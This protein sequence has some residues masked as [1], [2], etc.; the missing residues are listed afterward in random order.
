MIEQTPIKVMIVDDH[1]IVRDGIVNLAL[2]HDDI[3]LVGK[4]R[5]GLDLLD[6]LQEVMPDVGDVP[7]GRV[8]VTFS[9]GLPAPDRWL[10]R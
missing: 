6:Q 2:I 3:E 9:E 1:P 5:D 10:N 7:Q 4:A 8:L